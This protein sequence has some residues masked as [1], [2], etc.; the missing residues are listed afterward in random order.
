GSSIGRNLHSI[1]TSEGKSTGHQNTKF[2]F[3]PISAE[4][5]FF[6]RIF[7]F[8]KY[9]LALPSIT[10]SFTSASDASGFSYISVLSTNHLSFTEISVHCRHCRSYLLYQL[11]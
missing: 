7:P 11:I 1:S 8:S 3:C 9:T 2:D 4:R 5:L 10:K 6:I